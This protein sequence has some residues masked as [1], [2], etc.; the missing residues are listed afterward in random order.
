MYLLIGI[1]G[2]LGSLSRYTIGKIISQK[3]N[4]S[5]PY[6]TYFI[7]ISGAFLLGLLTSLNINHSIYAFFGDGFLGAFTTFSPLCGRE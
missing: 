3:F 1:G 5:F 6:G 7:N 4:S 2:I